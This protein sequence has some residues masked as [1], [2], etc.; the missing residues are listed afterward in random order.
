MMRNN[1]IHEQDI[2]LFLMKGANNHDRKL[3][4]FLLICSYAPNINQHQKIARKRQSRLI[5]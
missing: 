1:R 3:N 2:G 5:I 4:S